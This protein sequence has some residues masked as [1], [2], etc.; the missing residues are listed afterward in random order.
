[1]CLVADPEKM[2][3]VRNDF[4][5]ENELGFRK[6]KYAFWD[7]PRIALPTLM[8]VSQVTGHSLFVAGNSNW[9]VQF[10]TGTSQVAEGTAMTFVGIGTAVVLSIV[11]V[12]NAIIAVV[13]TYNT[14]ASYKNERAFLDMVLEQQLKAIDYAKCRLMSYVEMSRESMGVPDSEGR[15]LVGR[16]MEDFH[17]LSKRVKVTP[18]QIKGLVKQICEGPVPFPG[19]PDSR[20]DF[21]KSGSEFCKRMLFQDIPGLVHTVEVG[22]TD[23]DRAHRPGNQQEAISLVLGILKS[24]HLKTS[25]IH[26]SVDPTSATA[27][28]DK[29]TCSMMFPPHYLDPKP[30]AP[31]SKLYASWLMSKDD[32]R[33]DITE[34]RPWLDRIRRESN[35][36]R[37][38]IVFR[39]PSQKLKPQERDD[40]NRAIEI[41]ST[42][43]IENSQELTTALTKHAKIDVKLGTYLLID[44]EVKT[45]LFHS[46]HSLTHTNTHTYTHSTHSRAQHTHTGLT[47]NA[48]LVFLM[49]RDPSKFAMTGLRFLSIPKGKGW[50]PH[51]EDTVPTKYEY[52]QAIIAASKGDQPVELVPLQRSKAECNAHVHRRNQVR[53]IEDAQ[54][55]NDCSKLTKV[56]KCSQIGDPNEAKCARYC[57]S[58][59]VGR[60]RQT[61]QHFKCRFVAGKGCQTGAK[62]S[63]ANRGV[64]E[65]DQNVCGTNAKP[66]AQKQCD[67]F[68]ERFEGA[69]FLDSVRSG[70]YVDLNYA[71]QS[72]S[73]TEGREENIFWASPQMIFLSYA[74]EP[75]LAPIV[76]LKFS[77]EGNS[78]LRENGYYRIR[79][80]L[81]HQCMFF[82]YSL[83]LSFSLSLS[84]SSHLFDTHPPPQVPT[85][86]D[87]DSWVESENPIFGINKI[88][89]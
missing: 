61:R 46:T 60:M 43:S 11:N 85:H 53:L 83:S 25:R 74:T 21:S 57:T 13:G 80:N 14:V 22:S 3:Q 69:T 49:E 68:E 34:W 58:T 71:C 24:L 75:G 32:D 26:Q 36:R 41:E 20:G 54:Q 84:L 17:H 19:T 2:P 47:G 44:V 8:L 31:V 37:Y 56:H 63:E 10:L 87:Q 70:G 67:R 59:R 16:V 88:G 79:E 1:M 89:T 30:H 73:I 33:V 82:L 4:L 55:S 35:G 42:G 40:L 27:S 7:A 18:K 52:D 64:Y 86:S 77:A 6:Y 76:D 39:Q 51:A 78:E 66:E 28:K 45:P 29:D 48:K 50:S 23:Q 38:E 62:E 81:N 5:R 65:C 72:K 9:F 12:V 15:T